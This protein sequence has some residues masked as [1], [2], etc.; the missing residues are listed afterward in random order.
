MRPEAFRKRSAGESRLTRRR[1]PENESFPRS[2]DA[3]QLAAR[4]S[5]TR[6]ISPGSSSDIQPDL[7]GHHLQEAEALVRAN[8]AGGGNGQHRPRR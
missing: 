1:P 3:D 6:W 5:C 4:G 2:A 8:H 7:V